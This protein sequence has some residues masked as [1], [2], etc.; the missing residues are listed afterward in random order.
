MG[1]RR[2]G[3]EGRREIEAVSEVGGEVLR[4]SPES[5]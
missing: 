5:I 1:E 3:R 4:A 2:A